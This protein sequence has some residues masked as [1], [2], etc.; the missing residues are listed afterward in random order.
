LG[1]SQAAGSTVKA[2]AENRCLTE[3]S[4]S[5]GSKPKKLSARTIGQINSSSKHINTLRIGLIIIINF[6]VIALI[7]FLEASL[8]YAQFLNLIASVEGF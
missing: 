4:G 1:F 7:L 3:L 6:L 5:K 2:L 8:N